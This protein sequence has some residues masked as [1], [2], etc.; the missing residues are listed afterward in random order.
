MG[1]IKKKD[2]SAKRGSQPSA[3]QPSRP[4]ESAQHADLGQ[5]AGEQAAA[6]ESAERS[7]PTELRLAVETVAAA[8]TVAPGG[9]DSDAYGL[10]AELEAS[11]RRDDAAAEPMPEA[12][13][14]APEQRSEPEESFAAEDAAAERLQEPASE[15][16]AEEPAAAVGEP[17]GLENVGAVPEQEPGATSLASEARVR[18]EALERSITEKTESLRERAAELADREEELRAEA[19]RL[20]QEQVI[21]GDATRESRTRLAEL[22]EAVDAKERELAEIEEAHAVKAADLDRTAA[23]LDARAD[24]ISVAGDELA[25]RAKEL[26]DREEQVAE[27]ERRVSERE[28]AAAGREAALDQSEAR[29]AEHDDTY[30]QR[31]ADLAAR[32]EA[33]AADREQL[34]RDRA[35]WEQIMGGAFTRL[36]ELETDL[37]SSLSLAGMLKRE[38]EGRDAGERRD[39]MA[40]SPSR[41]ETEESRG[42]R[43]GGSSKDAAEVVE[44]VLAALESNGSSIPKGEDAAEQQVAE[45][46]WWSRQLGRRKRD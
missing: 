26:D 17:E 33:L 24:R 39:H 32:Q 40:P 9:S 34:D 7:F 38:L 30:E 41:R 22:Q 43:A 15:P 25:A 13:E 8:D 2:R 10:R 23:E 20:E 6:G 1:L 31:E 12:M 27:R 35:D 44:P 36:S 21:W 46:D 29:V 37:V 16:V 28:T 42:F 11:R 19:A 4:Q 18:L 3:S 45:T 14:Q 5:N